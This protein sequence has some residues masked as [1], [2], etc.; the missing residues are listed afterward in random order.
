[1]LVSGHHYS[2][3][4]LLGSRLSA[5]EIQEINLN[6]G[7]Y[8]YRDVALGRALILSDFH[9]FVLTNQRIGTK[10]A[11]SNRAAAFW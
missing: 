7:Q 11:V 2:P 6:S 3:M 1:M 8:P 5:V 10:S 9:T 4:L